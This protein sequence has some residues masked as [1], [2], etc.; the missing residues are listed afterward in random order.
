M[1]ALLIVD[2]QND[3]CPGGALGVENAES[4]VPVIN[5]LA[6]KF[7]LVIA[8]K[9]W[10]PPGSVHFEK[11][12]VHCVKNTRGAEFHPDLNTEAI[13]QV[14][15]KGTENKDDGYSAFEATNKKLTDYLR[16]RNVDTLYVAGLTTDYCVKESAIDSAKNGF[17]T[18]V[19]KDA[20]KAVNAKEGDGKKA[21]DAMKAAGCKMMNAGEV[22]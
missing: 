12:P 1:R 9:D 18:I 2:L 6:K 21:I 15:L 22:D 20:I 4:V 5:E 10:H 8:S 3:F 14:F 11:W 13:D 17:E 19:I 7:D 16:D